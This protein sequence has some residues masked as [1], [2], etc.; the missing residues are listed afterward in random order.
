MLDYEEVKEF[1]AKKLAEDFKGRG[2][3]ESAFYHTVVR[4]Y[5]QGLADGAQP[6]STEGAGVVYCGCDQ[7]TDGRD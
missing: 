7:T 3:F 4:A 6:A 2:R 1:F 5:K